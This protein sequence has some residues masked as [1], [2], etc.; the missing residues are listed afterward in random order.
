MCVPSGDH[1]GSEA[2][3]VESVEIRGQAG[4]V[5]GHGPE[6]GSP[7]AFGWNVWVKAILPSGLHEGASS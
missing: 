5:G 2:E 1:A 3:A 6:A 4:A 7:P